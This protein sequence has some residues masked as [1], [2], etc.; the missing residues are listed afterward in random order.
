MG[1][2]QYFKSLSIIGILYFEKYGE[3]RQKGTFWGFIGAAYLD[4]QEEI[5]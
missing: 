1:I 4:I 5:P 2:K 3:S